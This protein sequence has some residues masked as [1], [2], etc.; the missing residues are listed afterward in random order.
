[1][2][3]APRIRADGFVAPCIPSLAHKPPS[4][5]DWVHEIKHDGCR[6]SSIVRIDADV[7]DQHVRWTSVFGSLQG[8]PP[9]QAR[10]IRTYIGVLASGGVASRAISMRLK[11]H[12]IQTGSPVLGSGHLNAKRKPR[13]VA[14]ERVIVHNDTYIRPLLTDLVYLRRVG[15]PCYRPI[16]RCSRRQ[17]V[18]S[19]PP[20][21]DARREMA[22]EAGARG[23]GLEFEELLHVELVSGKAR[24]REQ[25][26]R[27]GSPASSAAVGAG[28]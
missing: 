20:L 28:S 8:G 3:A 22:L 19:R 25:T 12:L 10:S 5:P 24:Y 1:M 11:N 7:I 2:M 4:G 6:R 9:L 15:L 27:G 21:V 18:R 13:A 23:A 26:R 16:S 17:Q 14:F